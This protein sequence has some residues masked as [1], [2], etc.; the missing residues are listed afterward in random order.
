A[1]RI[2]DISLLKLDASALISTVNPASSAI[3]EKLRS[4]TMNIV[5]GEGYKP[6]F[7]RDDLTDDL[8]A[9]AGFRLDTEIVTRQK[10]KQIIANIKK[11]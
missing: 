3:I 2:F 1:F 11:G 9:K 8:H 10:I 5:K 7:T 4:M 6:N